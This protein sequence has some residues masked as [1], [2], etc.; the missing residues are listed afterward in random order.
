MF[1][2]NCGEEIFEVMGIFQIL[3]VTVVTWRP[4][5]LFVRGQ[6]YT[7]SGFAVAVLFLR[8]CFIVFLSIS[9]DSLGHYV[10]TML[11]WPFSN[12]LKSSSFILVL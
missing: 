3:I 8:Q 4:P 9:Q 7:S 12:A 11:S 1:A 10:L 5:S 2:W 6:L